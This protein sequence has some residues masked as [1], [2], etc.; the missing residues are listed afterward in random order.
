[1]NHIE[2][3][4]DYKWL[5]S[6]YRITYHEFANLI[7]VTELT[8]YTWWQ[9]LFRTDGKDNYWKRIYFGHINLLQKAIETFE[10]GRIAAK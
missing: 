1:M 2:L 4:R 3:T 7:E 9:R 5:N 8:K 6:R 10:L